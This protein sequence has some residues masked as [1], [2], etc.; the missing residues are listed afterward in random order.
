MSGPVEAVIFDLDGVLVDTE[1]V[2][3]AATRALVAPATLDDETYERFIGTGGFKEGIADTYG[4]PFDHIGPRYDELFFVQLR[5]GGISPL[6]GAED[7]LAAVAGRRLPVAVASQ[8]SRSWVEATLDAARLRAHFPKIVTAAEA[9]ADKP[10]PDI[11]L[12][13][14]DVLGVPPEACIAVEDSVHG[15]A[16][17]HAAGM[18][19]VQLTQASFTPPPQPGATAVIERWRDFD[20][21][22]LG[23]APL[24]AR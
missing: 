21:R 15:V 7:V 4:I 3:L 9:G 22:W 17:A 6:E 1:P 12:R 13:A 11:Y 24:A 20:E 5:N 23:G 14:A 18:L 2:H 10:A 19:V 16:S 8:S